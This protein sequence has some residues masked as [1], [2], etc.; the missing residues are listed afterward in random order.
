MQLST[1]GWGIVS[2]WWSYHPWRSKRAGT[3]HSLASPAEPDASISPATHQC[4]GHLILTPH[5]SDQ[6]EHWR[7]YQDGSHAPRAERSKEWAWQS[8][9]KFSLG[10]SSSKVGGGQASLTPTLLSVGGFNKHKII[11]L[12]LE[13]EESSRSWRLGSETLWYSP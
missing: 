10:S 3:V 1:N 8:V 13:G 4:L 11:L 7:P 2:A 6:Q 5:C 9:V 12:Q